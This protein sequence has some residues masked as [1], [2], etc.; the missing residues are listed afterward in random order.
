MKQKKMSD[1]KMTRDEIKEIKR[2]YHADVIAD[3]ILL[4]LV[5]LAGAIVIACVLN[6]LM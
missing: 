1:S 5:I 6:V 2:I 3:L 4:G